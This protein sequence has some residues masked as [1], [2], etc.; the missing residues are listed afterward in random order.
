VDRFVY[1]HPVK[2]IF[3]ADSVDSAGPEIAALGKRVLLVSGRSSLKT[4]GAWRRIMDS[5]SEQS[6]EI[7]EFP[8]IQ[9]N[10]LLS[11]V[12]DGIQ[13]ARS[14]QC[15]VVVG[16]GGGSVIDT[17]KAIAAGVAAGHDVW[18]FFTGKKS[19]VARLPLVTIPTIAGSGSEINHGIVLTNDRLGRKF[20]FGHRYL[21]P[22]VCIADPRLTCS[23][24]TSLTA[25]G[26]VDTLC[27]CLE[28]Y[29]STPQSSVPLQKG[30]LETIGRTIIE[31]VA[32]CIENPH[33]VDHRSTMLWCSMAAMSGFGT[34]GLGKVAFTLHALEHAV[35]AVTGI[36]HGIGLAALLPGWLENH[37]HAFAGR[38]AEW[39]VRVF[40]VERAE[41]L[42]TAEQTISACRAFLRSIGCPT[43]LADVGVSARDLEVMADH[44]ADQARIWRLREF[45]GESIRS[46]LVRCLRD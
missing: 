46:A 18:K 34:A 8:G 31:T 43:C 15:E 27:H 16:A 41:P 23:V 38:V 37:C 10:P 9:P 29:L 42:Q 19:V 36:A 26:A 13:V 45:T 6:A 17:A 2:I 12:H 11:A 40:G 1:H 22:D 7:T 39:G 30:V 28:P 14:R 32:C 5:F 4:S 44:A 21:I 3:G 33:S 35:S 20:G 24:P 25:A